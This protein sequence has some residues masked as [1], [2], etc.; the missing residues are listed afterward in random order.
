MLLAEKMKLS[1]P[2]QI[3]QELVQT[4]SEF[5]EDELLSIL[6]MKDVRI[7]DLVEEEE[8]IELEFER[9]AEKVHTHIPYCPNCS[10]RI[11]KVEG[12]LLKSSIFKTRA[13][14]SLNPFCIFGKKGNQE[15]TRVVE[16]KHELSASNPPATHAQG[17]AFDLFQIFR[18]KMDKIHK[19]GYS[20]I[21]SGK[22]TFQNDCFSRRSG[23]YTFQNDCFSRRSGKLFS[24][25]GKPVKMTF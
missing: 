13:G 3:R 22:Y 5:S 25:T 20:K 23:K 16:E 18:R 12:S 17:N 19:N 24:R 10:S 11:T 14:N 4:R 1:T 6:I 9:A 8:V 7:I 15:N 2:R 21:R